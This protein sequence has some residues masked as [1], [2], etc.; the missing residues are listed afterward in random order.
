MKTFK[1]LQI[2]LKLRTEFQKKSIN[3]NY[4]YLLNI[5]NN[6]YY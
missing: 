5:G 1:N 2:K 3:L 4:P 6:L